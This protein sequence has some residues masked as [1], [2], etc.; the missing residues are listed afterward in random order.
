MKE[1]LLKEMSNADKDE[2]REQMGTLPNMNMENKETKFHKGVEG[3][4]VEMFQN[5]MN[6]A[7]T[8]V[9]HVTA[10]WGDEQYKSKW[11]NMKPEHRFLIVKAVLTG[12]TLPQSLEALPFSFTI[13]G[14]SRAAFDQHARQRVG[15]F[16]QS[17]G[18]RDNSRIDAGFRMPTELWEDEEM[19]E[20]IKK[21]V[22]E[23][24]DLYQKIL[25]KGQGSFQA[26]R[27][28]MSLNWTHNYKYGCN[29]MALRSYC[30]QRLMACEMFDTTYTA[31]LIREEVKKYSPFLASFLKP[32]CDMAK[33]CT[34]HQSY[35]LSEMF[36]C[37]FSGC[38]RWPDD[39][40]Y[41]THNHSCSDYDVM[42][43]EGGVRLEE[44]IDWKMY[45]TF[46]SLEKCDKQIFMAK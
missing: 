29:F 23:G 42:A 17:Q 35:T 16:F 19:C 25:K 10:T 32:R 38:N 31:I 9:E 24:K 18:V 46:E 13:R 6:Y 28:I 4:S 21:H 11:A 2:L 22:L 34:Y 41:S 27:C 15:A 26:A 14:A 3:I 30:S 5:P 20:E 12:S 33:K 1:N 7:K 39:E 44:P 8:I 37:L 43:K 36:G 40:S 45:E